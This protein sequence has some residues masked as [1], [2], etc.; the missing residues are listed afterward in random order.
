MQTPAFL[1]GYGVYHQRFGRL[2]PKADPRHVI[3]LLA[4]CYNDPPS[5]EELV[6]RLK[7]SQ[8]TVSRMATVLVNNN[9][10]C[11]VPG[12]KQKAKKTPAVLALTQA[13]QDA[14]VEFDSE[15]AGISGRALHKREMPFLFAGGQQRLP[16]PK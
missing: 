7:V 12:K 14:I 16:I 5:Q 15:L 1:G 8:G 4:Y 10:A 9:L 3:N 2:F 11:W 6:Y 13:G